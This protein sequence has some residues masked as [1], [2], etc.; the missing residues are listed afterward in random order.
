L[1][2][3]AVVEGV[4]LGEEEGLPPCQRNEVLFLAFSHFITL[5][6]QDVLHQ[7]RRHCH[8]WLL[9]IRAPTTSM[10]RNLII[11]PIP[12]HNLTEVEIIVLQS[13]HGAQGSR[14]FMTQQKLATEPIEPKLGVGSTI[15]ST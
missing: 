9:L 3:V 13:L 1:L 11:L 4:V 8:I 15:A 2:L 7:T 14:E 6:E 5:L 10:R 12:L